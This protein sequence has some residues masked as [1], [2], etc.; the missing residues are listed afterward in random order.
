MQP[1]REGKVQGRLING[2]YY[3]RRIRLDGRGINTSGEGLEQIVRRK[4]TE[5]VKVNGQFWWG[6]GN[7]LPSSSRC[8]A[9]ARWQTARAIFGDARKA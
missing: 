6:I 5:R 9:R 8:R 2:G 1:R 4:E 3:G 7:S